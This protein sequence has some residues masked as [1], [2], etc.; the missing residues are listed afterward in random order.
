MK[1]GFADCNDCSNKAFTLVELLV[2]IGIIGVL[3]SILIPTLARAKAKAKAKT[4]AK[5]KVRKVA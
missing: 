4:K 3:T 1:G 2:V 5:A